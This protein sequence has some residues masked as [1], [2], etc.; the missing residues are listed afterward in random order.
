MNLTNKF[1][2]LSF[3]EKKFFLQALTLSLG[4]KIMIFMIP[5]RYY[6]KFLPKPVHL[7]NTNPETIRNLS[8]ALN[9]CNRHAPWETKCLVEA[10]SAKFLLYFHGINSTIYFGVSKGKDEKLIAH[11]W[12]KCGNSIIAGKKGHERFTVVSSFA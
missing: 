12:L 10:I 11:A 6:S 4:V 5:I 1:L 7:N 3:Q 8:V 2:Q 9:R